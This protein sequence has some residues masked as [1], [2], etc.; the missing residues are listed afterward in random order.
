MTSKMKKT[1]KI[2]MT[3]KLKTSSKMNTASKRKTS[4]T[5]RQPQHKDDLKN[6]DE[7]NIMT[8]YKIHH[9]T[10]RV[11]ENMEFSKICPPYW[12]YI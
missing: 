7:F 4:L 8:T 2:K 10:T 9:L 11:V 3:S 1:S 6:E 12:S 5:W